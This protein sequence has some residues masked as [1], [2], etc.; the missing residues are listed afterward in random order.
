MHKPLFKKITQVSIVVRNID[1]VVKLYSDVYGMCPWNIYNFGPD[2]VDNMTVRGKNI[3]YKMKIA[4]YNAGNIDLELIEPLDNKSLYSEFLEQ[5]GEGLHHIAYF[6]EDY[7]KTL[8]FF[9]KRGI[10]NIQSGV[11]LGKGIYI[12]LDSG[13]ELKHIAEIDNSADKK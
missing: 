3:D 10:N 2:T 8:E 9:Q 5:K 4:L 13:K 12:Y 1:E 6:V 11:W 7:K